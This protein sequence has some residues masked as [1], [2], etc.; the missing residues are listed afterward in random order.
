MHDAADDLAA[1]IER[2]LAD[3]W[4]T[5]DIASAETPAENIVGTRAM[6]D[7]VVAALS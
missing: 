7:L 4:R 1:A 5:R 6:G 2:V 3:G